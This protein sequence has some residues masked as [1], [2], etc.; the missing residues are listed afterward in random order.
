MPNDTS[1]PATTA[2]LPATLR[3]YRAATHGHLTATLT[4]AADE[5]ERLRAAL[6]DLCKWG[7][8]CPVTPDE[9]AAHRQAG[10][11]AFDQAREAMRHAR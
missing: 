5:I 9:Q 10:Y 2:D 1:S 6:R 7:A 4:A 8:A 11:A 3:E